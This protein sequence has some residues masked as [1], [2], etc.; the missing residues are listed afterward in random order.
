ME[1]GIN[2]L[3]GNYKICNFTTTVSLHYLRKFLKH[4]TAHYD[5]NCQCILKHHVVNGKNES[6]WTVF[7][8][9]ECVLKMSASSRTHAAK[10]SLH[11]IVND[12]LETQ[13]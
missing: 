13:H 5:T 3:P 11:C 10:R 7:R 4:K 8:V 1:T 9:S 12:L 6:V 2:T